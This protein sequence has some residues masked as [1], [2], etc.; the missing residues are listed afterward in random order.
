MS[1]T[2]TR[3]WPA[4][5]LA[6]VGLCPLDESAP[7]AD[8]INQALNQVVST[9][10]GESYLMWCRYKRACDVLDLLLA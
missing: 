9:G 8:Q 6:E 5:D 3:P 1:N 2:Q 4:H 10:A 7:E